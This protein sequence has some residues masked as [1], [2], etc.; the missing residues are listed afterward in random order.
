MGYWTIVSGNITMTYYENLTNFQKGIH[1]FDIIISFLIQAYI[2]MTPYKAL[3]G[4]IFSPLYFYYSPQI[5]FLVFNLEPL[6]AALFWGPTRV[7]RDLQFPRGQF[8]IYPVE[9]MFAVPTLKTPILLFIREFF[10]AW[11]IMVALTSF[12]YCFVPSKTMPGE[13]LE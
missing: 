8:K 1:W 4:A 10:F 7:Y 11:F 12:V 6:T 3:M 13:F 5:F 9:Q 2:L